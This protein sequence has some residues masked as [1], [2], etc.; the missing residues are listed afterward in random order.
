MCLGDARLID[1]QRQEE[2]YLFWSMC[3]WSG[4]DQCLWSA[5][6]I[7]FGEFNGLSKDA[8]TTMDSISMNFGAHTDKRLNVVNPP[9]FGG[10][11]SIQARSESNRIIGSY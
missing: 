1:R 8:G 4:Y 7:W 5:V 9:E 6:L 11:T 2:D 3:V 10:A